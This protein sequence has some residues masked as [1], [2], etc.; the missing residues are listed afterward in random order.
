[1][2]KRLIALLVL[3]LAF[4]CGCDSDSFDLQTEY[5]AHVTC[6]EAETRLQFLS[7]TDNDTDMP[8]VDVIG[9]E[10]LG[11]GV[12]KFVVNQGSVPDWE[13]DVP[14]FCKDRAD[15]GE[16][17]AGPCVFQPLFNAL[18]QIADMYGIGYDEIAVDI[19]YN[20][21]GS[22]T[23]PQEMIDSLDQTLNAYIN[24]LG[25]DA[26]TEPAL[27]H[28][29]N[30]YTHKA[31]SGAS[32]PDWMSRL[33]SNL[34]LSRISMP[35]T[36]DTMSHYGGDIVQTQSLRLSAQ[37]SSGIRALDIRCRHFNNKFPIHHGSVYQH[38]N[39]NDVLT[40][41]PTVSRQ[42]SW[43]DNRDAGH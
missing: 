12:L 24:G 32:N 18:A 34:T 33:D 15:L 23:Y 25:F 9:D 27:E 11:Y 13:N 14:A 39:F 29:H 26:E 2:A 7:L 3:F 36:H 16:D 21:K 19:A 1:M 8:R 4:A 10:N 37:L 5:A 17:A 41:A 22:S 31:S 30:A 20:T 43:R 6:D 35:G 28:Q 42:P 40:T 38:A